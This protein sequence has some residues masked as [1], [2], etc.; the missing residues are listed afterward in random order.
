MRLVADE[1]N[2][3]PFIARY[4]VATAEDED[5][6]RVAMMMYDVQLECVVLDKGGVPLIQ[7]PD[8]LPRLGGTYSTK[9]ASDP[10]RDEPTDR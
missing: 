3:R 6:F 9:A 10:T 4:G 8:L 1:V 7:I 5:S 2:M